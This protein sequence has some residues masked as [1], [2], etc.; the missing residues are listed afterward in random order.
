[1]SQSQYD[2]A[3]VSR[4]AVFGPVRKW[5]TLAGPGNRRGKS[6][7]LYAP[8]NVSP[9]GDAYDGL[10]GSEWCPD[11][12]GN[13][14]FVSRGTDLTAPLPDPGERFDH[15]TAQISAG[16]PDGPMTGFIVDYAGVIQE[17]NDDNPIKSDTD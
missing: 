11:P 14:V 17:Y 15:I 8:A 13:K 9:N 1:M 7:W 4:L 6:G 3:P 12:S 5:G 2:S 16:S 10:T